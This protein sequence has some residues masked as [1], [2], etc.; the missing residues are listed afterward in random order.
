MD[1]YDV[2]KFRAEE[3]ERNFFSLRQVEWK[4]V[5]QLYAGYGVVTAAYLKATTLCAET[6][7][8][9]ILSILALLVLGRPEG[10]TRGSD[11]KC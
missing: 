4:V 11:L 10:E 7:V 5:L 2:Y 8:I 9:P 3:F 6:P 1:T